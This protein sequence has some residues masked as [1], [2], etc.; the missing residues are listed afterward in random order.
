MKTEITR[1]QEEDMRELH[2]RGVELMARVVLE[3][4]DHCKAV[5]D[6]VEAVGMLMLAGLSL[7]LDELHDAAIRRLQWEIDAEAG[8]HE[9]KREM[10]V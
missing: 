4:D 1:E 10:E 8:L 2:R 6:A 5:R 9:F 3:R 7:E